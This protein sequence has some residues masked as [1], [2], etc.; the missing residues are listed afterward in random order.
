MSK[1]KDKKVKEEEEE[2]ADELKEAEGTVDHSEP[3]VHCI[4]DKNPSVFKPRYLQGTCWK[5]SIERIVLLV[6]D[7]LLLPLR[8]S[9]LFYYGLKL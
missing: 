7:L 4:Y 3:E 2:E 8:C 6:Q 9:V 5:Y 1:K